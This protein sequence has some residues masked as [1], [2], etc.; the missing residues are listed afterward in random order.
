MT[1][2]SPNKP[3]DVFVDGNPVDTPVGLIR[4]GRVLE[5]G[6]RSNCPSA[7][8]FSACYNLQGALVLPGLQDS[9]IHL[10]S[11]GEMPSRVNLKG[12]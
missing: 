10:Y 4:L 8:D 3:Q 7:T 5:L 11:L 1:F 9:H 6:S 2:E 12:D